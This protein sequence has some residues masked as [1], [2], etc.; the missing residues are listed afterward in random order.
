MS[1][2]YN[3]PTHTKVSTLYGVRIVYIPFGREMIEDVNYLSLSFVFDHDFVIDH[4]QGISSLI[5]SNREQCYYVQIL[6]SDEDVAFTFKDIITSYVQNNG[7][8]LLMD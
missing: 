5:T 7:G 1:N 3:I 2:E 4:G 8:T 6:T